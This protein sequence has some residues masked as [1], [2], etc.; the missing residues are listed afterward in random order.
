[1]APPEKSSR[2]KVP[3]SRLL[4][5]ARPEAGALMLGSVFL[6]ISSG[7]L[8]LFP[9]AIRLIVDE[10]MSSRSTEFLN[11][12]A[13]GMAGIFL[14][15]GVAT[16][17]RYT[18]FH[19]A[20]ER[21]V[22]RLR[23]KLYR[24]MLDQEIAFFDASSSGDLTNRLA[25]DTSVLQSALS[26]NISIALRNLTTVI[27]GLAMLLYTSPRLM[28]LM[29]L[30]VPP[31]ALSAVTYGRKVRKLGR[32]MQDALG[33]ANEAAAE[34]LSGIRTIR[35][36]AAEQAEA[37]RYAKAID[38][39]F[40]LARKQ[41]IT[42]SLFMGVGG[43]ASF[44]A[45]TLVFWYGGQ[46]VI[47][48]MLT[49][50][51]LTSFL[52]YSLQV[53]VALGALSDLWAGLMR[54]AGAAERVFE[55]LDRTPTIP[56]SGGEQQEHVEGRLEFQDVRFSYPTRGDVPVIRGL[57]LHIRPGEVVAIVGPS[58]A[59]KT[60]I[61]SL[62]TRFYD[63]NSGGI[64]LD[65]RDLRQFDP[66]WLRRQIG[67][68][69]QEPL[70]FSTTIAENIRYGRPDA[71]DA[72]V[73]AA[74][75]AAN[76]HDFISRFSQ[77][78]Q[79]LVGERGVQLSGGQKQRVAIARAMLKNA[80]I[81]ILD[82]ATSALDAESEHLVKEALYRLMGGRTT[83]II[84]HRLS[85]VMDANRVLVLE[86]GKIVQSGTHA[87]LMDEEGLYRRLVERQFVAA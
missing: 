36:F 69:A 52:V 71:T 62:L 15:Q 25:S 81:L 77:G 14:V 48:D 55:L 87:K 27:G 59:G 83:L 42:S 18:L 13:V 51:S 54:A 32:E 50:G 79:T 3:I 76:A 9:Q 22:N 53:A 40:Q 45:A 84:A 21:I 63:P 67:I 56:S 78:Y 80:R 34:S 82:E 30:V 74:A 49:V 31:V 35:A 37:Q 20:G 5:L 58:G 75:M 65:G 23:E 61:A 28:L 64:R 24:S 19:L 72:Q 10:A 7:A 8:L 43:F 26:S 70:L 39:A 38:Q 6:F 29:L 1:M 46:L 68:V 41:I 86:E 2:R 44:A 73:E 66:H 57:D 47:H 17:L 33:S 16:A 60:T 11:H 4:G 85:T 12:V